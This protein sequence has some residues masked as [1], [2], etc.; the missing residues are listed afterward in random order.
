VTPTPHDALFRSTFSH[1]ARAGELLRTFLD[2]DLCSRID[3]TGLVLQSGSFVDEQLRAQHTDLLFTA[4]LDD[5][6]LRIYL[7]L[8]HQSAPDRWISLW[9]LRYM[10]SIWVAHVDA[11]PR[12]RR[13]PPILPAVIHHGEKTWTID[14]AFSALFDIPD[15]FTN[16]IPQFQYALADLATI[17]ADTLRTRAGSAAVRMALLALKETRAAE[18]LKR[19]LLGWAA[20]LNELER[21]PEG[22]HV[23][24]HVFRYLYAVRDN[25]EFT[26]IDISTL[27]LGKASEAIMTR[28]TYLI[29]K[30]IEQGEQRII[31][32]LLRGKF[33]LLPTTV[34]H[35]I[36]SADSDTLQ[37][38]AMRLL[39]A[40]TLDEVFAD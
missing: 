4:R 11:H 17:D 1:P 35:R 36:E 16:F 26:R 27:G 13:L 25:E 7:L 18:D 33:E 31:L 5:R 28:E 8:E 12:T 34:V 40:R 15:G 2:P 3:W 10:V 19:L 20:V 24:D 21:H 30:G 38:W 29:N 22:P 39:A 23:I 9:L 6:E 14:P 37:R 32:N